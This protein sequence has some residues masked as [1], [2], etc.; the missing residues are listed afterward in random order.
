MAN[1]AKSKGDR[2]ELE[3]VK[4]LCALAETWS[5]PVVSNP[6]RMLGAGRAEDVGDVHVFGDVTIQVR[7][8]AMSKLGLA[9]LSSA[10]DAVRQAANNPAADFAVGLVPIPRTKTDGSVRWLAATYQW[11]TPLGDG[12]P[13]FKLVGRLVP[14]LRDDEGPHGYLPYPR[15]SRVGVFAPGN[16]ASSGPVLV[17]PV[18]AW[19][20]SYANARGGRAAGVRG[21]G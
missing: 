21:V 11:P 6:Q 2:F 12:L 1:S 5:I 10:R 18:E 15:V 20:A 3:A 13:V 19:L 16:A 9:L 7:A 4:V 17:A 8:Y 14:W